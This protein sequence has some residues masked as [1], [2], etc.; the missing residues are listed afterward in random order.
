MPFGRDADV[1]VQK[2]AECFRRAGD[3]VDGPQ[4]LH[5]GGGGAFG[6]FRVVAGGLCGVFD[7]A[8]RVGRFLGPRGFFPVA[9][10]G[11]FELRGRR[12]GA[13]RLAAARKVDE[14]RAAGGFEDFVCAVGDV[15]EVGME[16]ACEAFLFEAGHDAPLV[17]DG[18]DFAFEDDVH[19]VLIGEA[20]EVAV[21]FGVA[22]EALRRL[23]GAHAIEVHQ[24][25]AGEVVGVVDGEA[26]VFDDAAVPYGVS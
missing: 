2:D 18:F 26:E 5:Q 9:E 25:L 7:V 8:G 12:G 16:G 10:E 20:V 21:R 14:S 24:E 19:N 22:D 4:A 1:G 6:P 15:F 13:V 17:G 3:G 11:G 23:R